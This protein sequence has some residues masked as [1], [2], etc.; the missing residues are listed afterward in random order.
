MLIDYN[1]KYKHYNKDV[2]LKCSDTH[3]ITNRENIYLLSLTKLITDKHLKFEFT[4]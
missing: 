1:H 2:V 4:S 3:S